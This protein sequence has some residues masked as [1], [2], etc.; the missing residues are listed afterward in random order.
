MSENKQ[1]VT[2]MS[3]THSYEFD[4]LVGIVCELCY[5]HV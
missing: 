3:P 4:E 1:K 2:F 5:Q